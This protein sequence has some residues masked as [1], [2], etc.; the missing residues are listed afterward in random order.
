MMKE[1]YHSQGGS[2]FTCS[3][4]LFCSVAG[5]VQLETGEIRKV[6]IFTTTLGISSLIYAEAFMDEKLAHFIE[7]S[8]LSSKY[9][10]APD[11]G[12]KMVI[13]STLCSIPTIFQWGLI[14][15]SAG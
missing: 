5:W 2:L 4:S 9:D 7:G 1:A 11:F 8:M 12:T 3:A 10:C 6:H 13:L 14:L 15:K